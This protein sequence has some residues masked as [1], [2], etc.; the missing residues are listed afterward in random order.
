[1]DLLFSYDTIYSRNICGLMKSADELIRDQH[2][3]VVVLWICNSRRM[4][5]G[6]KR[7]QDTC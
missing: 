4:E 6:T 3:K 2:K 7:R 5:L 1:M